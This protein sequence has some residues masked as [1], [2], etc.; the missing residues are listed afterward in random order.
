MNILTNKLKSI[1]PS[2]SDQE[3]QVALAW[4]PEIEKH[5]KEVKITRYKH[6]D[7]Y[8]SIDEKALLIE[9]KSD[10]DMANSSIRAKVLSQAIQYYGRFLNGRTNLRTPDIIFIADR[11]ECFA[12]HVNFVNKFVNLVD[13]SIRPSDQWKNEALVSALENDPEVQEHSIVYHIDDPDFDPEKI[14]SAIDNMAKGIVRIVPIT[15]ATLKKGFEFF[16]SKVLKKTNDMSANEL[17]GRYFAFL[18]S[19]DSAV[20]AKG[21]LMGIDGFSP[22]PVNEVV[23]KQ[24][25]ERFG[26]ITQ[27]DHRQLERLY[28]TLLD[29]AERRRNGQFYT[30]KIWVDEAHKR[31]ANTLGEDWEKSVLTWDCCSGTKALTRDY[32]W[33]ELYLSTLDPNELKSSENL[34]T[35][36]R[37]T[38]VFDFLNGSTPMLPK[39]LVDRLKASKNSPVA[40]LINPPYGQAT[41]GRGNEHKENISDTAVKYRMKQGGMGK[42][43]NELTV[44]FLHRILELVGEFKLR[45]VVVGL[46]SNPAWMTGDA[47]EMFR[48][49]WFG[50]FGFVESFGFRSEEFEGVQPGWAIN[51][52]VWKT[53]VKSSKN[54]FKVEL[55]ENEDG[56][57]PKNIGEHVYYNLDGKTPASDWVRGGKLPKCVKSVCTTDGIKCVGSKSKNARGTI[58][59]GSLGYMMNNSNVVEKNAQGVSITSSP[60]T[61]ANG[62]NILPEN[63]DRVVSLFSA[64]RCSPYEWFNQRDLYSAPNT[65]HRDYSEWQKDCYVFSM[66]EHQ[67]YQTSIKGTVDGESY[68]FVNQFYPFT[69]SDTYDLLGWDKKK[70]FKDESRF[71]RSSGKL[72]DLTEEGKAVLEAFEICLKESASSRATYGNEHPEL[73]VDRWDCGWRQLKGLFAEACPERLNDLKAKF[74]ILRKK[75]E[76][77]VFELGFLG[78]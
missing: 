35:D 31:M 17:V 62:F 27:D 37:E 49:E 28:D 39:S 32:E 72:D 46:F 14:F 40:F 16:V 60:L 25:K 47:C 23:A 13:E 51:F 22:I 50:A 7:A 36:A 53:G 61:I 73:Q 18:K 30:P 63:F 58:C 44:Q 33:G 48:K 11:N 54:E 26:A 78:N 77:K 70:N 8:V 45:N 74:K 34:S 10:V 38:F 52:S 5:W 67:S 42:A 75:M 6:C 66:F 65:S 55:L 56:M 19:Q 1:D 21:K 15:A 4:L 69:K 41:S 43:A 57:E 64:R 9:F 20:I 2:S 71:V 76:P 59:E 3:S 29:N 68:D 12:L 24:F